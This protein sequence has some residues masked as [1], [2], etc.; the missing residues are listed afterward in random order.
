M[1]VKKAA[2]ETFNFCAWGAA[3]AGG[4]VAATAV[5]HEVVSICGSGINKAADQIGKLIE[6]NRN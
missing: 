6:P 3:I 1:N 2:R 4:G 5:V